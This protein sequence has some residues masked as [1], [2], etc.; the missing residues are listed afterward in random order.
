MRLDDLHPNEGTHR[1]KRRVG[2]GHGSG[3]GKTAGRGTKGQ[4]AR[5]GGGWN[6]R[7]EGGQT[8]IHLR[9]PHRRG[10][11]NPF[12]VEYAIVK[13]ADLD[14]FEDGA[15][16]TVSD[17]VAAGL[18]RRDEK[19]PLKLLANGDITKAIHLEE[20]KYTR[21]ALAKLTAAGGSIRGASALES[22]DDSG[23]TGDQD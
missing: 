13:L 9:L 11:K 1:R 5:S 16:L 18:V 4:Q 12:R 22:D 7:F 20:L 19:R 15:T 14:R 17:L 21:A 23:D 3:R 10:F 8:P 2:R 6:P